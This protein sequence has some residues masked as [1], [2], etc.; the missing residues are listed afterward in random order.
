MLLPEPKQKMCI[1]PISTTFCRTI[2]AMLTPPGIFFHIGNVFS[3]INPWIF[4][5]MELKQE[6]CINPTSSRSF[7][8][9]VSDSLSLSSFFHNSIFNSILAVFHS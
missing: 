9:Y 4:H 5:Y 1:N 8:L 7:Q 6:M 2:L 3:F